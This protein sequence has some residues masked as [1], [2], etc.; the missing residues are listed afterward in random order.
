[1]TPESTMQD[2]L[3]LIARADRLR[4]G[5]VIATVAVLAWQ[6]VQLLVLAPDGLSPL[7]LLVGWLLQ[8]L[9][10]LCFLP[11]LI[12]GRPRSA[13][14]LAFTLLFYVISAVLHGFSPGLTGEMAWVESALL[15][16]QFTLL[17]RFVK[18]K[19]ATQG[20]AL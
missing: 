3:A 9:G 12:K 11:G 19:R 7:T 4:R 13:V 6:A 14:W 15:V 18:A 5:S 16:G 20:G 8:G 1:M 10:L 2:E 17:I